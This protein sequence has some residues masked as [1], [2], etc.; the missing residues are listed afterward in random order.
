MTKQGIFRH[1]LIGGLLTLS[2]AFHAT[3]EEEIEIYELLGKTTVPEGIAY[4]TTDSSIYTGSLLT[5]SIQVT[6][7]GK[8]SYFVEPGKSEFLP[9]VVGMA[10]D[11]QR[12]RLWVCSNDA[13]GFMQGKPSARISA[14]DLKTGEVLASFD[15]NQVTGVNG[16]FLPL[17]NDVITDDE[18]NAYITSSGSAHIVE[19]SSDLSGASILTDLFPAHEAGYWLNGIEVTEDNRYLMV[20]SSRLQQGQKAGLYR[21][22]TN[23][24]EVSQVA[25]IGPAANRVDAAGG[26]GML[27]LDRQTLLI[28]HGDAVLM[29]KMTPDYSAAEVTDITTDTLVGGVIKGIQFT[30]L[31]TDQKNL[32]LTN[33]QVANVMMN[34]PLDTP[35]NVYK[36]PLSLLRK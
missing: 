29:A 7:K 32:Y 22:E 10:I 36:I 30:S 18:G 23:S 26:D 25:L 19:V 12:H 16:V 33:A 28:V 11:E 9:N 35:F 1:I 8:S 2:V 4:Y 3:A 15:H 24:G 20:V 17:F 6:R 21:I 31:A 27:F 34:K 14:V 13:T 5:S